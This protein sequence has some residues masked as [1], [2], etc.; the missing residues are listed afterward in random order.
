MA[1]LT[2]LRDT[3]YGE[4]IGRIK[5]DDSTVPY[6]D[7][8]YWYYTRFKEGR[9]YPI[10]ARKHG[11][12]D[13]AEEVMFDVNAMSA[14]KDYFRVGDWAVSPDQ[15]LLACNEDAVDRRQF[16]LRFQRSEEH[17]SELQSPMRISYAV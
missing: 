10:H 5:Q 8:D 13:A 12:L 9:D 1:P 7:K 4:L 17:T 2:A 11:S 16:V 15:K 14:G 3:L 6:H